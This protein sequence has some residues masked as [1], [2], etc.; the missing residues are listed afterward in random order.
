MVES[1]VPRLELT[2]TQSVESA[3]NLIAIPLT[4]PE[5]LHVYSHTSSTTSTRVSTALGKVLTRLRVLFLHNTSS[6]SPTRDSFFQQKHVGGSSCYL[7]RSIHP[8]CRVSITLI[9]LAALK[10]TAIFLVGFS[11]LVRY[12]ATI[13]G[14]RAEMRGGQPCSSKP[15]LFCLLA[16]R[17][18]GQCRCSLDHHK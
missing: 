9:S 15:L 11:L 2:A 8:A 12:W 3:A 7:F 14:P 16:S 1:T 13:P 4:I 6:R 5:E 17:L 10:F 18:C